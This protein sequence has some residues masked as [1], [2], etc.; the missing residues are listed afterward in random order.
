MRKYEEL[1][2]E[3]A[4]VDMQVG[5]DGVLTLC[6]KRIGKRVSVKVVASRLQS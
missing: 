5:S 4:Q 1:L 3:Q 2:L 6:E